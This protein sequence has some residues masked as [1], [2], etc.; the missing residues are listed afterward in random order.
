MK[1]IISVFTFLLFSIISFSQHDPF[2]V[3]VVGEGNPILLFPGFACTGEVWK[4]TVEGLSQHY[5]CHVFTFAGFGDVPPVETPWLSRIK[6]GVV[7]YVKKNALKEP[8]II[9]HSLGG[10]LGLWMSS[11]EEKLFKKLIIVDGLPSV[12][13]LM[14]PNFDATTIVYDNPFSKRQLAMNDEEFKA[15]AVQ[16]ASFMSL[17]KE[18]HKQI[19]NWILKADRETYVYGYTDLLK[20]D[21]R[22]DMKKVKIPV[23][24]LAATYPNK[25]MI[26]SNYDKQY[27]Y[28]QNLEVFYADNSAH[29]IMYDQPE[30]FINQ[31][32]AQLE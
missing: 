5:E 9:G 28:L 22:E 31:V 16:T 13:A 1:K 17:N 15:M 18:K 10:T 30:W 26:K 29:F 20:L 32:K 24:L 11:T 25:E 4:E 14:I 8:V 2:K 21:L 7:N 3:N 19:I 12:G 6:D 27:K 23:V